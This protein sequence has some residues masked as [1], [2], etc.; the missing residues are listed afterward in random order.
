MI[1]TLIDK[2]NAYP[3]EGDVY[4]RVRSFHGY[5]KL[6]H[7]SLDDMRAGE[8][9]A[10]DD[11]KEDPMTLPSERRQSPANPHGTRR[12]GGGSPAGTSSAPR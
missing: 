9:I 12:W 1:Q 3:M 7:R 8:R 2:G 4:Y 10:V 5:G 11:R 6:S